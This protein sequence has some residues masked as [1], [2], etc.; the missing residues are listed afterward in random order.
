MPCPLTH[1]LAPHLTVTY[2]SS[3]DTRDVTGTKEVLQSHAEGCQ[4]QKQIANQGRDKYLLSG[5]G[6][7]CPLSSA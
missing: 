7:V 5:T 3:L 4:S 6:H 1:V 2:S